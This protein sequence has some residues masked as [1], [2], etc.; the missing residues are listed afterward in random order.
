MTARNSVRALL[1]VLPLTVALAACSGAS[2]PTTLRVRDAVVVPGASPS[3]A[4]V[5]MTITASRD[6]RLTGVGVL[7]PSVARASLVVLGGASGGD[8][9]LGHLDPQG[10][11][12]HSHARALAL[13]AG[14][15]VPLTANGSR[16]TLSGLPGPSTGPVR[17]RLFL[18][19]R[20][21]VDVAAQPAGA[22]G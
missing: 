16:I 12:P 22:G 1:V 2:G 17:L 11:K 4:T 6:D 15:A 21:P 3:A 9:H 7:D 20:S 18:A 5:T 13:P 19:G 10:S 14:R 8:G